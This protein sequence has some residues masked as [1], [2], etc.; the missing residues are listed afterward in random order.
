MDQL[1]DSVLV[2]SCVVFR[3]VRGFATWET[4]LQLPTWYLLSIPFQTALLTL[5][6]A[7]RM[8]TPMRP[9]LLPSYY[10]TIRPYRVPRQHTPE[11]L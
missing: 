3:R 4:S 7:F 2:I 1:N 5:L 9:T 10:F 6:P 11:R 8:T